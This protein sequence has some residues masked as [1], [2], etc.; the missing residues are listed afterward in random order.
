MS[1]LTPDHLQVTSLQKL[2]GNWTFSQPRL[3]GWGRTRN[4]QKLIG[5]EEISFQMK[6]LTLRYFQIP[7]LRGFK[8]MEGAFK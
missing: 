1:A 5:G 2:C 4:S 8:G 6:M 7:L 3:F